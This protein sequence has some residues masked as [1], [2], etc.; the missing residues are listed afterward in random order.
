MKLRPLFPSRRCVLHQRESKYD[1]LSS[2]LVD[3]KSRAVCASVKNFQIVQSEPEDPKQ[4]PKFYAADGE[5]AALFDAHVGRVLVVD[6][7]KYLSGDPRPLSLSSPLPGGGCRRANAQGYGCSPY[8]G[9]A[10][11]GKYVFFAPWSEDSV[12]PPLH[13]ARTLQSAPVSQTYHA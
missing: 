8:W 10:A 5:G 9:A 2:C 13:S 11:L 6:T 3:F 1:R 4:R 7:E 12:S